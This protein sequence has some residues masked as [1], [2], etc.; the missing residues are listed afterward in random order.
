MVVNLWASWCGPCRAEMPA[1]ADFYARYGDRV[2][3]VGIDYEDPQTSAALELARDT[4]VTYPLLADPQG[5]LQAKPPYGARVGVPSFAFVDA[6]GKA[7]LELG[8]IDSA[9]ELVAMAEKHL[10]VSL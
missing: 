10:G 7:T 1:V 5:E 6:D 2:P 4:G 9:D 8:G 3:V